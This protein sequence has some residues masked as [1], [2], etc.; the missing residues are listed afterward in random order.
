[1]VQTRD[2]VAQAIFRHRQ[3]EEQKSAR[4]HERKIL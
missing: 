4:R 2:S 3:C 1:M